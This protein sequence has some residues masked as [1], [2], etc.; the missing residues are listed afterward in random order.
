MLK[1]L[2]FSARSSR[3]KDVPTP[4]CDQQALTS[5]ILIWCTFLLLWI[6]DSRN[7][8]RDAVD[9]MNMH[10]VMKGEWMKVIVVN[11]WWGDWEVGG[12]GDSFMLMIEGKRTNLVQHRTRKTSSTIMHTIFSSD[13]N[14]CRLVVVLQWLSVLWSIKVLLEDFVRYLNFGWLI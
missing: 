5:N 3:T 2:L 7:T 12:M 11:D 6:V 8:I 14:V 4:A 9:A 13:Q 1:P 10:E